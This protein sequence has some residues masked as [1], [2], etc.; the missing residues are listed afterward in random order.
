[1]GHTSTDLPWPKV[2]RRIAQLIRENR[3]YTQ[4]EQAAPPDLSGQPIT[5]SGDTITIGNGDASHDWIWK[6][7]ERRQTLTKKYNELFNSSRPRE[8]DGRHLVFSGMN[9]EIKLREH[10]HNAVA[11]QLYGGNTLLSH[12]ESQPTNPAQVPRYPAGA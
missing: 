9:P 1:M 7:P 10:Q 2:Q 6:D 3:F 5:R 4:E 12:G 11:H 8:Y